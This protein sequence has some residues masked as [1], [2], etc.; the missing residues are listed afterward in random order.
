MYAPSA[1]DVR[2]RLLWASLVAVCMDNGPEMN[3]DAFTEWARCQS[4][5]DP[6]YPTW[7]AETIGHRALQPHISHQSARCK[8]AANYVKN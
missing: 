3:S 5:L 4:H 7:Q 8:L 6:P 1:P 2:H